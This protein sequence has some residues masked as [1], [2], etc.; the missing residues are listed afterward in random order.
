V[1]SVDS[2]LALCERFFPSEPLPPRS[3]AMLE[4]CSRRRSLLERLDLA[5][6]NS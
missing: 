5:R 2:A 3:M 6:L 4:D 1:T